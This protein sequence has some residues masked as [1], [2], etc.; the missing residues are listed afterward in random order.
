MDVQLVFLNKDG[1]TKIFDL[2]CKVVTIGRRKE[3]DLCIPLM[4]ASRR[5]CQLTCNGDSLKIHDLKSTN[6]TYVNGNRINTNEVELNAGDR[7][8]IGPVT[9]A[10]QID[11]KGADE[12]AS[13]S[14]N[15]PDEELNT[16]NLNQGDTVAE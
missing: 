10:V 2:P 14:E 6:G 16:D 1:T 15:T 11:G 4:V 7:I 8:K 12:R 5:H 9:L 13:V 3:C